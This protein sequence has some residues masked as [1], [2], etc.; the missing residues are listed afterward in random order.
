[1]LEQKL[2]KHRGLRAFYGGV[3]VPVYSRS[4]HATILHIGSVVAW[5]ERDSFDRK[6]VGERAFSF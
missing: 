5:V 1:M 3:L 6:D 2:L 4:T